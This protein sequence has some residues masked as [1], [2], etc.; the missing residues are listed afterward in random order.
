MYRQM[1]CRALQKNGWEH[2]EALFTAL[3][4]ALHHY[5]KVHLI[6]ESANRLHSA[7]LYLNSIVK[8]SDVCT[9]LGENVKWKLIWRV[10]YSVNSF[11][12]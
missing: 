7:R 1:Q 2:H 8:K 5:T 10:K 4:K 9:V 12:L 6:A 11:R 3:C